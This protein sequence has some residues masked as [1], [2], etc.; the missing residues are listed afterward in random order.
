MNRYLELATADYFCSIIAI[1]V[2]RISFLVT[3]S[4]STPYLSRYIVCLAL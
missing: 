2:V 4:L 3:E 1:F